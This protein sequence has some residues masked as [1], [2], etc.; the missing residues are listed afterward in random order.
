MLRA[1]VRLFWRRKLKPDDV[2]KLLKRN[3]G[4]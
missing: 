4:V 1:G 2:A 3:S